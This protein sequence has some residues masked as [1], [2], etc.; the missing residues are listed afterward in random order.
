MITLRLGAYCSSAVNMPRAN[1]S[2]S[3][4]IIICQP[5]V[6]VFFVAIADATDTA[7]H[8]LKYLFYPLL[9]RIFLL[10]FIIVFL[11]A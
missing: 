6:E 9:K 8:T 7:V 1:F 2:T 3:C 4:T 5:A 10:L 11:F